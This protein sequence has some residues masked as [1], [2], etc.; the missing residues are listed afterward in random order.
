MKTRTLR[1][2]RRPAFTLIEMMVVVAIIVALAGMGIFLMMGQA[3]KGNQAKAKADIAQLTDASR[4]FKLDHPEVGFPASLQDLLQKTDK[5][6]P[7]LKNAESML[8]PWSRPYQYDPTGANNQGMAPDIS[9]QPIPGGGIICNW[10]TRI[11][12]K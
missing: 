10:S 3:D 8:D 11:V 12:G 7:Y 6:G 9:T 1:S 4:A 2:K 5:G